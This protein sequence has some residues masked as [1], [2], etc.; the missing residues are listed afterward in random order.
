MLMGQRMRYEEPIRF[1]VQPGRFVLVTQVFAAYSGGNNQM[2]PGPY[3]TGSCLIK[4]ESE[5]CLPLEAQFYDEMPDVRITLAV[6][7]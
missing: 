7:E 6:E 1:D 5:G 3:Q 2:E 4:I